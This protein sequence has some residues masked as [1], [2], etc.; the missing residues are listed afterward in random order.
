MNVICFLKRIFTV[1]NGLVVAILA[2]NASA[3]FAETVSYSYDTLN[4][5]TKVQYGGGTVITYVYDAMGNRLVK[6]LYRSGTPLNTA[7]NPALLKSPALGAVVGNSLTLQWSGSDPN[8][9]DRLSYELYLGS[10]TNAL[11]KI[12]SGS[13]TSFS[14]WNL[15]A[16]S[17]YY[18]KV[19]TRD[20]QNAETAGPLW[21]FITGATAV[22]PT[23]FTLS[24][25]LTGTGGGTI[26][27]SPVGIACTGAPTDTCNSDFSKGSPVTLMAVNDGSSRLE[28]WS[29]ASCALN[30]NCIITMDSD[31]RV[32]A[33]FKLVPP[34][35]T[36]Y[37]TSPMIPPTEYSSFAQLEPM[38][39]Y[40]IFPY[41]LKSHNRLFQENVVL[42]GPATPILAITWKGGY[43]GDYSTVTGTTR[44][45]GTV[46]IK[47]VTVTMDNIVI[48]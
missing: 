7:P 28:S 2:A 1:K 44:I 33:G 22:N 21:S 24:V 35:Q 25:A 14:P 40:M 12:W 5:L 48:Q 16:N 10:A 20:S 38:L 13:Q 4:R 23:P 19:V 45:G 42:D 47:N 32:T 39:Q 46:T 18:W 41:L 26:T 11:R 36:S 34:I 29:I 9:G 15:P 3:S 8:P 37:P 43:T 17:T 31:L 27:S 6:S 30:P